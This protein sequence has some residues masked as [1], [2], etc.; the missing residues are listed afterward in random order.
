MTKRLYEADSYCS[1]FTAVVLSC[2]PT[3]DGRYA[4]VLDRT[5]F[6]PEGG[7]QAADPGTLGDVAVL[8]VQIQGESIVHTTEAPLPVGATVEGRLDWSMRFSRMQKHTAEHILSGYIHRLHGMNNIGFH[9]GSEDV[10]LDIDGELSREQLDEI[11][12]LA[13]RAVMENHPVTASFPDE[14]QASSMTYRSKKAVE[15]PLRIVTVE[16]VDACACCAPHVAYTG[17]IGSIKLLESL[18]YKGGMRIHMQAGE[19]ALLDHQLRYHQ[20]TGAA[21]RLSVKVDN[22]TDAVDRLLAERDALRLSLREANR[23]LAQMWAESVAPSDGSVCFIV[24]EWDVETMRQ[25][26]NGLTSRHGGFCAAFSGADGAYQ[27]VVGG[28]G[29]LKIFGKQL[30]EA[31]NGKGGGSTQQI[32]GRVQATQEEI[33]AFWKQFDGQILQ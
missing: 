3:D 2:E 19:A 26:V 21:S 18:R 9:L 32:Q 27:Y 28:H 4:V 22:L 25:L 6:F 10:T 17:E 29:D 1:C 13:N 8:D 33:C 15:G 11:E 24:K 16:G 30:N 5:A 12:C 14:Q 31:L 7:G 20:T 23:R